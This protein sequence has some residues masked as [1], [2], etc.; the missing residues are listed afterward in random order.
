MPLTYV[1]FIKYYINIQWL[2][3]NNHL[4]IYSCQTQLKA[5]T[6]IEYEICKKNKRL[7]KFDKCI[8]LYHSL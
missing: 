8:F 2:F 7:T 1:Y 6:E 4:D 5:A 3:N